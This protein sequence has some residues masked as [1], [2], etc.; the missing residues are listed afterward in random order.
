VSWRLESSN[1]P[2][3]AIPFTGIL[4][5][6]SFESP[7]SMSKRNKNAPKI[8]NLFSS[9]LSRSRIQFRSSDAHL[10]RCSSHALRPALA[11]DPSITLLLY[12]LF[13]HFSPFKLHIMLVITC[14]LSN[15]PSR[16]SNQIC[17]SH[18]RGK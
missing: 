14:I 9:P 16:P 5:I 12:L 1:R 11:S 7:K 18:R 15:T 2:V 6:S 8:F 3:H 13:S 10:H 4:F 17:Y